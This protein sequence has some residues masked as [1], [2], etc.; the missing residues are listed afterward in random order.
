MNKFR[1]PILPR[2]LDLDLTLGCG[3]VFTWHR[4]SPGNWTGVDGEHGV[5]LSQNALG[6]EVE[7]TASC[8]QIEHLFQLETSLADVEAQILASDPTMQECI[9]ALPGLRILRNADPV[10]LFFSFM[11]T[12]CNNL[13]RI[14]PMVNTLIALGD[15]VAEFDGLHH[16]PSCEVI[17]SLDEKWLREKGFGYRASSIYS[18]ARV[19]SI[20][21]GSE[22]LALLKEKS[23]QEASEALVQFPGIGRKVADCIAL[24]GLHFGE[25]VPVD[26]HLWQQVVRRDFPEW[27]GK[28]VTDLRYR[29]IGDKFRARFG[30]L[31]G[32]AH[33]YLF[34]ENLS[35]LKN[36][37]IDPK[38]ELIPKGVG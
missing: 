36:R 12:P 33:E 18:A 5:R 23:Y 28:S 9:E 15:P 25:A 30:R 13:A 38:P 29:A 8:S 27:Q 35:L 22:Y 17:A 21:G 7:T 26:T 14:R 31:S 34:Y 24:F 32:W 4:S 10:A 6:I 16:F 20:R 1:I 37:S 19:L 11:C 3:Q 2:E